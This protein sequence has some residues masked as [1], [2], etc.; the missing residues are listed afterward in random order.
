MAKYF[1]FTK[2]QVQKALYGNGRIALEII[3]ESE[4]YP[5]RVAKATVNIPDKPLE[6]DEV[7]IKDWSENEGVLQD[8]MA[9]EIVSTPIGIVEAGHCT[10]YKCK[11]L[12]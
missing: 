8:L 6:E 9:L 10:A 2:E 3:D 11:L 5:E 4:G 1:K 12:I 7:F